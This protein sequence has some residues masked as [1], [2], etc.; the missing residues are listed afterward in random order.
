MSR[1]S[2]SRALV[3]NSTPRGE[4]DRLIEIFLPEEGL[5]YAT[6]YGARKPGSRFG[7][8]LEPG[9][10][11]QVIL[12][13]SRAGFASLGECTLERSFPAAHDTLEGK[14]ALLAFLSLLRRGIRSESPDPV[15]FA[16]ALELL[17]LLADG[18]LVPG[19]VLL[20]V[21]LL[22]LSRAGSLPDLSG[23]SVCGRTGER[24]VLARHGLY[25][26]SC[27]S[28]DTPLCNLTGGEV[29]VLALLVQGDVPAAARLRITDARLQRLQ[30]AL[31][32]LLHS[33]GTGT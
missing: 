16:Q 9:T 31:D 4:K 5:V 15:L 29:R 2:K 11:L 26:G 23:C 20:L 32:C 19:T 22:L 24:M 18:V 13:R 12:Q 33:A 14:Q 10:L 6:A 27:P 30:R 17:Q 1:T 7:A 21:R 3:L 8:L 28:D 25:C